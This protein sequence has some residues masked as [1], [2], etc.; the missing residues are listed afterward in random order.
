M[1]MIKSASEIMLMKEAGR[2]VAIAHQRVKAA[3]SSGVST[4]YLN[5]LVEDTILKLGGIPSFKG[6]YDYPYAATFSKNAVLVHGLPSEEMLK[7]GDIVSVDIGASYK[8]Y[9]SDAAWTYAVGEI[10]KSDQ[11]LMQVCEGALMEGLK[12]AVAGN[13]VGDISH[14]IGEW[15]YTH[16]YVT[17]LDHAGHGV[18]TSIHE[19]PIVPNF[20]PSKQGQRL[21]AGMTLA[22]EPVVL[23]LKAQVVTL[24]DGWSVKTCDNLNCA[25]VEHTVLIKKDGYEILTTQ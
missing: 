13:Y 22:I 14:A 19:E 17:A 10:S 12:M 6:L 15:I 9:H 2:I 1:A 8:G 24:D 16:G 5:Q 23:S 18:G 7:N 11:K 20:G 3:I 21:E 4:L 25:H